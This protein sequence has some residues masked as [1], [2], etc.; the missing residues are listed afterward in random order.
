MFISEANMVDDHKNIF[1]S[2][3]QRDS[4]VDKAFAFQVDYWDLNP[5]NPND[6]SNPKRNDPHPVHPQTY[7]YTHILFLL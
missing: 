6:H 1:L 3:S 5:S 2:L 7:I 4:I